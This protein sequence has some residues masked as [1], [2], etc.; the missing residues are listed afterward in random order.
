MEFISRNM[1]YIFNVEYFKN[2][3][4]MPEKQS[5]GKKQK[6]ATILKARNQEIECFCFPEEMPVSVWEEV[7]GFQSCSLYTQYPGLLIGT[8]NPHELK[9]DGAIKC[10]FTFDYVT[11]VPYVPGSSLKGMLR[12]CFPGDEKKKSVSDEYES[13]IRGI[14]GAEDT[15][16][17]YGL[18]T[19]I[20]EGRD[21]FLGAVPVV[22]A[23]T[24]SLIQMEYITPHNPESKEKNARFKDPNPIS[25][26]K[27]KPDVE[28]RFCFLL[29]DYEEDGKVR[30]SA[31]QKLRLFREL[32]M[33]MGVGAKTNVGFGKFG[34]R[35]AGVNAG[36]RQW[37]KF[38]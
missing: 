24:D 17:I 38:N 10:G 21:V 20:F 22:K 36:A 26:I 6:E 4:L 31:K 28:F 8:G 33:D 13:Y 23:G 16:D 1:H 3:N 15:L 12:S 30:I 34:A 11:G 14:L 25:Q 18:K 7:E 37:K 19:N 2:L 9:M 27:V 29:N 32:I 35:S 5:A